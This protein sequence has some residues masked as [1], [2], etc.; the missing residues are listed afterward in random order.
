M[1]KIILLVLFLSIGMTIQAQWNKV[2]STS[3]TFKI[4]NAG[5][6]VDGK[7]VKMNT[8]ITIDESNPSKSSFLGTIEANSINTGINLRDNHLKDKEE[9]FNT[10]K[11]PT[12]TMKSVNVVQKSAGI[13]TVTWDL[14]MK[15]V[16]RRFSS[17]VITKIEGGNLIAS[18]Q[19]K[20]NRNDWNLG[21]NSMTMGDAVTVKINSIL[22][23]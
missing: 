1:Q 13:Y 6:G 5:I 11:Y 15:G 2:K 12:M 23:K 16:A 22:T 14:T 3:V 10:S 20:I 4:K 18:T 7:F 21:G 8:Q 19:F 17:E 9:F